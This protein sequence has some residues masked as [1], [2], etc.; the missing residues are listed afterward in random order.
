M[1][2]LAA[3]VAAGIA[4]VVARPLLAGLDGL[5]GPAALAAAAVAALLALALTLKPGRRPAAGND[6]VGGALV[7]G[8]LL[9]LGV[10]VLAEAGDSLVGGLADGSDGL[11]VD[12]TTFAGSALADLSSDD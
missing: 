10:V 8:A 1:R 3:P 2:R 5:A 9:A 4:Y 6:A 11:A 7:G 12:T